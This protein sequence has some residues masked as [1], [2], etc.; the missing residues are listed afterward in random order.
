MLEGDVWRRNAGAA[1][2]SAARLAEA[3]GPD[4][5]LL[6]VE[7]NELFVRVTPEEA[8]ALRDKGFDFYDWG[9]GEARFVTAW[10][11]DPAD[12]AGLAAAIR[13]L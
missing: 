3:A 6:P 8:Q 11:S 1:N 5:L 7:A 9:P 10:D 2:D 13:A 12:V 4:R